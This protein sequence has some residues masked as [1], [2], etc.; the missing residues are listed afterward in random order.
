MLLRLFGALLCNLLLAFGAYKRRA[1]SLD[2]AVAGFTVGFIAFISGGMLFWIILGSFFVSSSL[3]SPLGRRRKE[4]LKRMHEKGSRRDAWQVIANA[5]VG[6]AAA[7]AYLWRPESAF[8]GAYAASFA[9]ANADT[10]ASEIGV[11]SRAKARSL[12]TLRPVRTGASGGVSLLGLAASVAGGGFI[13][14]V[15]L[16]GLLLLPTTIP[17]GLSDL[18]ILG[19][20]LSG[21]GLL[22]SLIDSLLGAGLQALYRDE[23]GVPTER[24]GDGERKYPLIKGVRWIT[25]DMVNFLSI[26][27]ASV[28]AL[29]LLL[30][31]VP[32]G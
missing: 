26:L 12:I 4:A 13:A 23:A 16:S 28:V 32:I 29:L 2:G 30:T 31:L 14:C 20:I 11:L 18:L 8:L 22:G 15:T 21:S 24:S 17:W 10:W 5:G 3:L 6:S 19:V 27:I 7:L 1:V 9:A 25:N